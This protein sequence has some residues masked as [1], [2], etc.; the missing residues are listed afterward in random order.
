MRHVH[1]RA[2]GLLLALALLTA[3]CGGGGSGEGGAPSGA[4]T[5]FA[6]TSLTGAFKALGEEFRRANPGVDVRFNFGAS[7]ALVS[8]IQLGA[9]ADV[10]APGD[11]RNMDKAIDA[12]LV[13]APRVFAQNALEIVVAKGNPK[14]LKGLADLARP[15][16]KVVLP[17][18]ELPAG[19]YAMRALER[20][21]ATVKPVSVEDD[22]RKVVD[23]VALGQADAGI[24]Y[25]TDVAAARDRVEGVAIPRRRNALVQYPVA[26]LNDAPNQAAARRFV[27]YLTSAPGQSTL[28]RFGFLPAQGT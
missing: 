20:Q 5:V 10:Y 12:G 9:S 23:K 19:R 25:T 3:G 18:E 28:Q 13:D 11:Q 1:P 22:A 16:L 7:Q 14:G 2:A 6:A 26:V 15:G 17:A 4:V 24:A 8:K 27:D 21:G